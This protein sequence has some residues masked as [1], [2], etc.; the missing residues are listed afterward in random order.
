MK[1]FFLLSIFAIVKSTTNGLIEAI[2]Q[3]TFIMINYHKNFQNMGKD[4]RSTLV[5]FLCV[6]KDSHLYIDFNYTLHR[7]QTV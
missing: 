4:H 3:V 7:C 5:C 1:Y 6:C 2:K